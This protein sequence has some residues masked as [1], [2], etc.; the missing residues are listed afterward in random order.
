VVTSS[1]QSSNSEQPTQNDTNFNFASSVA[2]LQGKRCFL[3]GQQNHSD[4]HDALQNHRL[5]IIRAT[6]LCL[7]NRQP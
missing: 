5:S 1:L 2:S 3:A 4:N 6:G 7:M